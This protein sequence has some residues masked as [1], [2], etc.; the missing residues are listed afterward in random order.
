MTGN[1]VTLKSTRSAI[2]GP[3]DVGK[4]IRVISLIGAYSINGQKVL[5][6]EG[7]KNGSAKT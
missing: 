7:L 1:R 5:L 4:K 3:N 6:L 2:E